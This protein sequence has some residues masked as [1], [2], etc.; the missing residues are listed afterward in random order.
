MKEAL[1]LIPARKGSKGLPGKNVKRLKNKPLIQYSIELAQRLTSNDSIC[2]STDDPQVISIAESLGVR[3]P[4]VRPSALASDSASSY[5]VIAHALS[6]YR[7]IGKT[8]EYVI[9]LQ[10]TSPFR[11]TE[12]V[13][14]AFDL[15][16][17]DV[18]MV[19][20][21]KSSKANPYFNLFEE[22]DQGFLSLSKE[23][24]ITKRQ[25]APAVYEYNGSIYIIRTESLLREGTL[26][27]PRI[28]KY[29]MDERYSV[30]IDTSFDWSIAELIANADKSTS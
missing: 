18:D 4:F 20:S 24:N 9:L 30:D 23:A 2:I 12:H 11:N 16:N 7:E 27:L 8:Y 29:E 21:V 28:K 3:V 22:D 26:K 15:M 25:E 1:F 14:E 10:P 17:P 6:H 13:K 5:Q 19:V